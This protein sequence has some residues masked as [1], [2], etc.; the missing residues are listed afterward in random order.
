[1]KYE[2]GD[3][4][5]IKTWKEMER[6]YGL[7]RLGGIGRN[8]GWIF[9]KTKEKELNEGFFD[10]I[11]TIQHVNKEDYLMA[12]IGWGWTDKMIKCLVKDCKENIIISRFEIM[13]L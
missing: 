5:K 4:V 2:V 13:D 3:K 12:E 8:L 9:I 1:M 6:E 10:R 7:D 11:L